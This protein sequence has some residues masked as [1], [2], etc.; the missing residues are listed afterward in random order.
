[1]YY[2]TNKETGE[3]LLASKED[4]ESQEAVILVI[5]KNYE[6]ATAEDIHKHF[7]DKTP[8]TSIRRAITNLTK[9]GLL[10]KTDGFDTG[11]YGKKIHYYA[12]RAKASIQLDLQL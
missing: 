2:N 8:I 9:E 10:Y 6:R 11:M 4:A 1:M 5:F 12:K 3:V 7:S